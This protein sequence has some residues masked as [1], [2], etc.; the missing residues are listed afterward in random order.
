M[1]TLTKRT[2]HKIIWH[3]EKR[4][5]SELNPALYNPRQANETIIIC[6]TCS[7]VFERDNYICQKCNKKGGR[8]VADHIKPFALYPELRFELSNGR[9]ICKECDLKLDTYGG[10]TNKNR[11]YSQFTSNSKCNTK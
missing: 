6:L 11:V 5:I 4:K 7:K 8:L 3:S 1:P 9:T 2:N 10:R